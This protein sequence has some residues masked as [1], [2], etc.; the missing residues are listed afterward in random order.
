MK[1]FTLLF[2]LLISFTLIFSACASEEDKRKAEAERK[3]EE[4]GESIDK[5]G[6]SLGD[7]GE[8]IGENVSDNVN[9][10]VKQLGD[11]LGGLAKN[12]DGET[13]EPVS[14]RKLK[15]FAPEKMMGM[16]RTD[17]EGQTSGAFGVKVSTSESTYKE[18]DQRMELKIVDT[19]GLGMALMGMAAWSTIEVDKE[20]SRGYERT[21]TIDGNKAFE[22]Y[23]SNRKKGELAMIV[24]DR[25]V[26]TMEFRNMDM[27]DVKSAIKKLDLDDLND[28]E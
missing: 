13:V 28:L 22:K 7:V 5:L 27:D 26:V 23:D 1:K 6:E 15:D 21:T 14:H 8:N 3:A 11:A 20:S 19:G 18:G 12:K 24:D 17:Y 4:L 25:F 10:A 2:G 16:E 9:D